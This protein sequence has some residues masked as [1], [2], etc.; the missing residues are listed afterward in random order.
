[1]TINLQ[2]DAKYN[3]ELHFDHEDTYEEAILAD[4]ENDDPES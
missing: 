1:M 3:D 4:P 2:I